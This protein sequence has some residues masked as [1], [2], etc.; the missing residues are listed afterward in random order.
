MNTTRT[1]AGIALTL[2]LMV[3]QVGAQGIFAN[4][5]VDEEPLSR[6]EVRLRL[7]MLR[8]HTGGDGEA[9]VYFLRRAQEIAAENGY[10]D[11]L[12]LRYIEGIDSRLPFAQRYAEGVIRLIP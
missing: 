6:D 10:R 7:R 11:V 3:G 5:G 4:W 1:S 2:L 9:R 8:I 12:V